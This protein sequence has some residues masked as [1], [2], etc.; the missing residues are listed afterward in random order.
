MLVGLVIYAL[1]LVQFW[2]LLLGVGLLLL[3]LICCDLDE[4][5]GC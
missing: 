5:V 1:E 4:C 3:V 2:F